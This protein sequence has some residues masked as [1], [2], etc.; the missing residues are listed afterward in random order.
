MFLK[1]A[2]PD[3]QPQPFIDVDNTIPSPPSVV[4]DVSPHPQTYPLRKMIGDPPSGWE[5]DK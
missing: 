5:P 4:F 3:E 2:R 1:L